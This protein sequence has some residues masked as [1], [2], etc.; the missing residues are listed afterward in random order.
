MVTVKLPRKGSW[1]WGAG[2]YFDWCKN[3]CVSTYSGKRELG[4]DYD[5]WSFANEQDATL[6]AL[7]WVK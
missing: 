5:E 4:K 2:K 7:I 1:L 3:N 6:F